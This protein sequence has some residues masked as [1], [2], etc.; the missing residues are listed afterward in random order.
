MNDLIQIVEDFNKKFIELIK[1]IILKPEVVIDSLSDETST[2]IKPFRYFSY[3]SSSILVIVIL[4][5]RFDI[6]TFWSEEYFLPSYWAEYY[7]SLD[8]VSLTLFPITGFFFIIAIASFLSFLLFRN[9]KRP[10]KNHLYYT[11]YLSGTL[12][13]YYFVVMGI[14]VVIINWW[15]DISEIIVLCFGV[16]VPGIFILRS[17]WF[18]GGIKI[19]RLIKSALI[20][21]LTGFIFIS[22]YFD[23]ELDRIANDVLFYKKAQQQPINREIAS[24]KRT[25]LYTDKDNLYLYPVN[26]HSDIDKFLFG[27]W[28]F[29]SE[30]IEVHVLEDALVKDNTLSTDDINNIALY[31]FNNESFVIIHIHLNE[32]S[33][34]EFWRISQ[35]N[36]KMIAEDSVLFSPLSS[37]LALGDSLLLT[38]KNYNQQATL[39]WI[40]NDSL[41]LCFN[42][43]DPETNFDYILSTNDSTLITL[44]SKTD[45]DNL[46][47]I[48]IRSLNISDAKIEKQVQLFENRVA[49]VPA[50]R[51]WNSLNYKVYNPW[52]S[53]SSDGNAIY[54]AYQLMTETTFELQIFKLD[55]ELNILDKNYF[56][57]EANLSYFYAY[58]LDGDGLFV[59][60]RE[61]ILVP[62]NPFGKEASHPFITWFDLTDLSSE[63]TQYLEQLIPLYQNK[64]LF[65]GIEFQLYMYNAKM[66]ILK[67]SIELLWMHED[68]IEKIVVPKKKL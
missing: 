40:Q 12:V 66:K 25:Q 8:E 31:H 55:K 61:F 13:V 44:V 43:E 3:I 39:Y 9:P 14:L 57:M 32:G 35:D 11:L 4:L 45:K 64:K 5:N 50:Y 28:N 47:E 21:V 22:F 2:Y 54:V 51:E 65:G 63:K 42:L 68:G 30:K 62:S 53:K 15:P 24:L 19:L 49:K 36:N 6:I 67:D 37:M 46:K 10:F 33:V 18:L 59:F 29:D 1:H 26:T 23:L 16:V 7:K 41:R 60:G 27:I 17:Q 20:M 56:T 52:M 48:S 38:G 58:G 34:S